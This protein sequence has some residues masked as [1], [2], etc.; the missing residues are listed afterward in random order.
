[1]TPKGYNNTKRRQ[2]VI[3]LHYVFKSRS[4]KKNAYTIDDYMKI[5]IFMSNVHSLLVLNQTRIDPLHT[6]SPAYKYTAYS[7]SFS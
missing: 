1:M 4:L 2:K 5:G 3:H 7:A 6:N